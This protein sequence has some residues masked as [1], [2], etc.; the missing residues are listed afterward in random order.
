MALL[1]PDRGTVRTDTLTRFDVFLAV[2]ARKECDVD[3]LCQE[4][5]LPDDSWLDGPI[6]EAVA[7]GLLLMRNGILRRSPDAKAATLF[8]SLNFALSY[9]IDYDT[10]LDPAV[11]ALLKDAYGKPYFTREN[12]AAKSLQAGVLRRLV[13]DGVLILYSYEPVVGR[14]VANPFLDEL[15]ATLGAKPAK[16][17]LEVPPV[18][19]RLRTRRLEDFATPETASILQPDA[20]T[21]PE[22]LSVS[23]RLVRHDLV[24]RHE[25]LLDAGGRRRY[26]EAMNRMRSHVAA[27][28][29][30]SREIVLDY[31]DVLVGPD[32]PG[33]GK[34][35]K[36]RVTVPNN[37]KF[38][39]APPEA[40]EAQFEALLQEY[41]RREP[42]G[43]D[44]ILRD[45]GWLGNEFLGVHP[46]EDGN[47]RVAR[48]V[49]S[50]FLRERRAPFEEIPATFEML[51][52]LATKGAAKRSDATLA[53]LLADVVLQALNRRDLGAT[54]AGRTSDGSP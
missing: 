53:G 49:L 40:V 24:R 31:H 54:G 35:R 32:D 27:G 12:V 45:G 50:H 7:S 10:Y 17:T 23:Q 47:S 2:W 46:F 38:K 34:L 14:L 33:A 41:A 28:R 18:V 9:G 20:D 6:E 8:R 42:E 51:F 30:L 13:S 39:V 48:V 37:P 5:F 3:Q 11:E 43:L 19:A 52:L 25:G 44:A 1:F 22:G 21:P 36:T 26:E 16:H 15:M 4:L 29:R